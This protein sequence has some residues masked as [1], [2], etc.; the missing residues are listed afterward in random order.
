MLIA[1]IAGMH[2]TLTKTGDLGSSLNLGK[3]YLVERQ[4][5]VRVVSA[6]H[7]LFL[8]L[9]GFFNFSGQYLGSLAPF[10][11]SFWAVFRQKKTDWTAQSVIVNR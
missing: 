9:G 11:G 6:S 5:S 10:S 4:G 2:R 1:T 7:L 3:K 8:F